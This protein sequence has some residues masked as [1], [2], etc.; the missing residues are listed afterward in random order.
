MQHDEQGG[1]IHVIAA[2]DM[3]YMRVGRF[4]VA[5]DDQVENA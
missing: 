1:H 4:T 5:D 3:K 2:V